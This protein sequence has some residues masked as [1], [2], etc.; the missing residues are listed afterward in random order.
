MTELTVKKLE[1]AFALG[2]SDIEACLYAGITKQTLYN[3]QDKNQEFI[4]RKEVLKANPVLAARQSVLRHMKENG[5]L[6]LRYLDHST[7]EGSLL[8]STSIHTYKNRLGSM[9]DKELNIRIMNYAAD[10]SLPEEA[11]SADQHQ[12]SSQH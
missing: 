12:R 3:Y 11:G 10:F 2:C 4:D 7:K 8:N 1:E 6:A 5:N 9:S